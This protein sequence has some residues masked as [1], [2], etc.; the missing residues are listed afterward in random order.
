MLQLNILCENVNKSMTPLYNKHGTFNGRRQMFDNMSES[1][2]ELQ[3]M[4]KFLSRKWKKSM[5]NDLIR[6]I[7]KIGSADPVSDSS[8]PHSVQTHPL[9]C[10]S[11]K[12]FEQH[13]LVYNFKLTDKFASLLCFKNISTPKIKKV[14]VLQIRARFSGASTS[15]CHKYIHSTNTV[16]NSFHNQP[17]PSS[18]SMSSQKP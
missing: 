3:I 17:L 6:K 15:Y 1:G 9:V 16:K 2:K 13:K 4:W 10:F 11:H 14:I 7:E 18:Q 12:A 5:L 8:W